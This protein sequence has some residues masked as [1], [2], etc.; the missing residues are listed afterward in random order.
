[1]VSPPALKPAEPPLQHVLTANLTSLFDEK[2]QQIYDAMHPY[3]TAKAMRVHDVAI[4]WKGGKDTN[5]WPDV[6]EYTVRFTVDWEGLITKNGYTKAEWTF[7][8]ES[9]HWRA[10][11]VSSNGKTTDEWQQT[12]ADTALKLGSFVAV[13]MLTQAER[14]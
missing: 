13:E 2:K 7:D 12:V 5:R 4:T 1:K 3:G 6:M 11:V 10:R 8:T 9:Q 14:R